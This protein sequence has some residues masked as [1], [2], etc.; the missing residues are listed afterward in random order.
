[1]PK[2]AVD[3][4]G[5]DHAPQVVVEGAILAAQEL[6]VEV[7]LVGQKEVV[8]KELARQ[9][10]GATLEIVPAS[11]AIAMHESPSSALR[12]K[13]SSMKVAF[14]MMKRG[15]VDAVVSAGN[16]GAMMAT[17][18]FVMG[19]LAQVAR[20]AILIVVPSPQGGTVII[21]AG[22]NVDCKP[23]HL[24]QFG[25]MG[26]SYAERILSIGNPRVGVLSNGEEES[27]GN[28]LTRAASELLAAAQVNYIG[29][30]E[31]RDIF[32]GKVDVV[33]CDGFTGNVALKTM[34]GL[35]SFA[36]EVLK[37]AFQRNVLSRLGY[38]MSRQALR[39][40]YRR[41]DYAE[42]GGAPL[43][44]LEGVAIIA[45]GGSGPRAIKN[46]IRAARD[47]VE[48]D[49]N[50]H[51]DEILSDGAAA[52]GKKEGLPQKIW[53]RIKSKIESLGDEPESPVETEEQKR[54]RQ[55]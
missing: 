43:I 38:L 52:E 47:E 17:G 13:D 31:G 36:G 30:V 37:G 11:E 45:H 22:A 44:G 54:G 18:M 2:I 7:V 4:M 42:Y 46:A 50:R 15:E 40:A 16:S 53:Q 19:T 39:E 29:Y 28:E 14:E 33:V 8:S 26:A 6:G 1:M 9:S 35:A 24:L 49:V 55:G 12:K 51:I 3:A 23:R 5:G 25:L 48:Q 34:E 20:P 21:D 10:P 27:K 32:N 41:L